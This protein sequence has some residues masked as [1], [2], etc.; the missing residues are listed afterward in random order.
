MS[1]L[2]KPLRSERWLGRNDFRSFNHRSRVMQMGYDK[3]DWEGK[4]LIA[5]VN[6]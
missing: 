5:I 6:S 3:K 2:K 4:P 1:T